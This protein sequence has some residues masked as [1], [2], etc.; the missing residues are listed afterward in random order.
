MN[1]TILNVS[2]P[3]YDLKKSKQFYDMLIGYNE[4]Q[5]ILYQ[6]LYKNEENIFFEQSKFDTSTPK[7]SVKF[8][9]SI[10]NFPLTKT[11]YLTLLKLFFL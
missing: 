3:V 5:E 10:V 1:W 4:N 8:L 11:H 6:T 9:K 7:S 2:I